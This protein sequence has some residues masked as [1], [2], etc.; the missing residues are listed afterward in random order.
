MNEQAMKANS[1]LSDRK[2]IAINVGFAI[3]ASHVAITLLLWFW[4]S[5]VPN[6]KLAEIATPLTVTYAI[7]AV[8]WFVDNPDPGPGREV[9]KHYAI[10]SYFLVCV[11]VFCLFAGPVF[12]RIKGGDLE[13]I[14]KFFLFVEASFGAMFAIMWS[15][16][17]SVTEKAET[18]ASG[19]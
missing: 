14:N 17:F 2:R 15:N 7:A 19:G 13:P 3:V 5:D 9:G 4:Y 8:K 12:H 6:S 11:L 18:K 10:M 1:S 16:L